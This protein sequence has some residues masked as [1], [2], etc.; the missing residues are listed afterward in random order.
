VRELADKSYEILKSNPDHP[1]LH[2]K[3]VDRFWSVRVG[4]RYR[5]IGVSGGDDI[6][7]IWIGSHADYDRLLE[8]R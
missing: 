6:V 4:R 7:W 2:F 5:A 1:S 8:R 3:R